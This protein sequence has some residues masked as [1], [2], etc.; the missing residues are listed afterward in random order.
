MARIRVNIPE[1]ELLESRFDFI[2]NKTLRT[3]ISICFQYI[4][5]LISLEEEKELP[6]PVSYSLYKNVIIH[7]ASIVESILHFGLKHQI[8]KRLVAES[9]VMPKTKGFRNEK[10][11]YNIEGTAEEVIGAIRLHKTEKLRANTQYQT[12]N[13]ACKKS[14]F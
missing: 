5:F 6:G 10:L 8:R 4:I 9:A 3:N 11:L 12:I 2:R 13:R 1:V 7:T 14:F